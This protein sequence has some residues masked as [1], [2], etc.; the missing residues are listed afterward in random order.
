[1]KR[2]TKQ[3]KSRTTLA[4]ADGDTAEGAGSLTQKNLKWVRAL[5]ITPIWRLRDAYVMAD[6]Y[7]VS[8]GLW[9]KAPSSGFGSPWLSDLATLVISCRPHVF[10]F[11]ATL[12]LLQTFAELRQGH[13]ALVSVVH[14]VSSH[15][16]S[17]ILTLCLSGHPNERAR[18]KREDARSAVWRGNNVMSIW[19]KK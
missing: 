10:I 3:A 9:Q 7:I 8:W 15:V 16:P 11:A 17:K 6:G 5:G 13:K 19:P 12:T 18:F 4:D 2:A 1:M 14:R